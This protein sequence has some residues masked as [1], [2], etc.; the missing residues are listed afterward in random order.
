MIMSKKIFLL[1]VRTTLIYIY[2]YGPVLLHYLSLRDYG[3][4]RHCCNMML[5]V[6]LTSKWWKCIAGLVIINDKGLQK[7]FLRRPC[8]SSMWHRWNMAG[9]KPWSK[10]STLTNEPQLLNFYSWENIFL[11]HNKSFF[12]GGYWHQRA[13]ERHGNPPQDNQELLVVRD[14]VG[15][16]PAEL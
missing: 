13:E 15:R 11:F 1:Y 2:I 3:Y 10:S 6:L 5:C 16:P 12:W 8:V 14:K 9:L 4:I 7:C